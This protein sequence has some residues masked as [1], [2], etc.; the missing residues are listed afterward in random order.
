MSLRPQE[1]DDRVFLEELVIALREDEPG[2]RH[3]LPSERNRLLAEQCRLQLAHYQRHFPQAFFLLII[4]EGERIGRI[5]LDHQPDHM[6]VVELSLLPAYQGHGIG[7]RFMETFQAEASRCQIPIRL[8]VAFGNSA[9]QFY[10]KLG[11]RKSGQSE[12]HEHLT[13]WPPALPKEE[14]G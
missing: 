14:R 6:R 13:W 1:E 10:E 8:S 12:L 4:A 9:F 2:F 7:R 11:F 3:L 5:Y